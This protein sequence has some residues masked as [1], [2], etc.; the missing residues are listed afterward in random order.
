MIVS[1]VYGAVNGALIVC[2]GAIHGYGSNGI[3]S[4]PH[5]ISKWRCGELQAALPV[6]PT[7][8]MIWP[9]STDCPAAT[10]MVWR[11]P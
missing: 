11:W 10:S 4:S 8:P 2:H 7:V 9:F 6:L 1:V 5:F 3:P